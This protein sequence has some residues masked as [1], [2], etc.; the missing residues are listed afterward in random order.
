MTCDLIESGFEKQLPK[1][2]T[3]LMFLGELIRISTLISS[4]MFRASQG[5]S[6]FTKFTGVFLQTVHFT[7]FMV[8]REKI[9][10]KYHSTVKITVLHLGKVPLQKESRLNIPKMK[11]P[12]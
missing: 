6:F 8:R 9:V 5:P 11:T 1:T 3:G 2:G 10:L 4:M 12:L 7:S